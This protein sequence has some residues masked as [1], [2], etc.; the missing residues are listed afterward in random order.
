MFRVSQKALDTTF[1]M[2]T[3]FAKMSMTCCGSNLQQDK[4]SLLNRKDRT[5]DNTNR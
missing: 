5:S 4:V 2:F 3:I 1:E